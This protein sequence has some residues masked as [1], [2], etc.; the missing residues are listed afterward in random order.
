MSTNANWSMKSFVRSIALLL[1]IVCLSSA[2]GFATLPQQPQAKDKAE[3]GQQLETLLRKSSVWN[4][5]KGRVELIVRVLEDGRL[6]L[7]DIEGE[8]A[9]A[10]VAMRV[11]LMLSRVDA[12]AKRTGKAFRFVVE[13]SEKLS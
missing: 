9:R 8:E 11:V 3:L 10:V 6:E 12:D 7:L 13:G 5:S 1:M 2:A 4:A